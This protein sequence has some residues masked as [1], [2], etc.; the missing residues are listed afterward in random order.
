VVALYRLISVG[1]ERAGFLL[2]VFRAFAGANQEL[3]QQIDEHHNVVSLEPVQIEYGDVPGVD[4]NLEVQIGGPALW[5]FRDPQN[6]LY[7]GSAATV[8][9]AGQQL[10]SSGLLRQCPMAA[11]EMAAFC[12]AEADHPDVMISAFEA[13]RQ[14]SK[15]GAETWRDTAVLLPRI[16]QDLA[17]QIGGPA[18]E[19]SKV[20]GVFATTRG[21]TTHI[22]APAPVASRIAQLPRWRAIADIFGIREF[23]IH[24]TRARS[25]KISENVPAWSLL[26]IGGIARFVIQRPPFSGSLGH[27][28]SPPGGAIAY[29]PWVQPTADGSY[30][31]QLFVAVTMSDIGH[32]HSIRRIAQR[33]S[34]KPAFKHAINI[35]PIGFGTPRKDK[36][37]PV[38]IREVLIDFDCIWII[39]NHRQ[40]Q[41]GSFANS[42]A[43]SNTASRFVKAAA[44]GLIACLES[45]EGRILLSEAGQVT[46]FGLFG[47]ARYSTP[48]DM[49]AMVRQVL[50]SMLCEDAD[51]HSARRIVV[52][53]PYAIER[54][55]QSVIVSLGEHRY[56]VE[57]IP[58]SKSEKNMSV[59]GFAMN[60]RLSART[61]QDFVGLCLSLV[62]GYGWKLRHRD[63]RSLLLENEGEAMRIWP[64][65][66]TSATLNLLQREAEYAPSRDL[67][68]SNQTISTDMQHQ[69]EARKWGIAHYSEL[70]RWMKTEY[71]M[72]NFKDL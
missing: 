1:G 62:A 13:T 9:A 70:G 69:A 35:R 50:Y 47:A 67:I 44:A 42:L 2:P 36:P 7:V 17:R 8:Q 61:D 18:S 20:E 15:R 49:H 43:A 39:A 52:L 11:A 19:R 51:L 5:A 66:T 54:G 72:G 60:V 6:R 45:A 53:W 26:G 68:V 24:S 25:E 63:G 48:L 30:G 4:Y 22:Y 23:A 32:V 27:L 38:A 71:R 12:E 41:T 64:V 57:L 16:K 65:T 46:G 59:V 14:I 33:L 58:R 31:D 10:L 29:G 34:S 37:S 28:D 55:R 56:N 3:V 40:R 21:E